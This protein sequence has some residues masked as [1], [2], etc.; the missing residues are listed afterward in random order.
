[1]SPNA[2][3]MGECG[4]LADEYSC[5]HETQ[6]NFGD[7]TPYLTHDCAPT[8]YIL[9]TV[10]LLGGL[11]GGVDVRWSAGLLVLELH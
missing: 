7:L 9:H 2:G 1:M 3:G 5:T 4:V 10:I 6:T 11:H 8:W